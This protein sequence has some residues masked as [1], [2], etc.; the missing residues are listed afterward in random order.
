MGENIMSSRFNFGSGEL[1]YIASQFIH[2]DHDQTYSASAGVAYTFAPGPGCRHS[3][4]EK[5]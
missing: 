5:S 1:A 3:T 2:L 4:D